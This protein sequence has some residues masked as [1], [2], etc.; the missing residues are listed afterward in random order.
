MFNIDAIAA[1]NGRLMNLSDE[2]N[3]PEY[4]A[5][6][7]LEKLA[8]LHSK[9]QTV[10][11][12]IEQ[13]QLKNLEAIIASGLWRDKMDRL[14]SEAVATLASESAAAQD[15]QLA[16]IKLQVVAGFHEAIAEAKLANKAPPEQGGHSVNMADPKVLQTFGAAQLPGINLI[17]PAEV[18]QVMALATYQRQTWPDVRLRDVIAHFNP[19]LVN[20]GNWNEF[21][22]QDARRLRFKLLSPTPEPTGIVVEMSEDDGEWSEWFHATS[23]N[24][25]YAIRSYTFDI[26]HNGLPRK[27]R[28]RGTAYAVNGSMTAV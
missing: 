4:Q 3:K 16:N 2:L 28:W 10:V 19:A 21:N 7:F 24:G 25:I 9:M 15:K 26:P 8:L 5:G 12:R 1:T 13:G 18:S 14:K 20:P 11:G 23:L 17:T 27:I 6:T 22:P